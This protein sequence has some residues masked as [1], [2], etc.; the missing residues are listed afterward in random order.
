[1]KHR[2]NNNNSFYNISKILKSLHFK[3]LA[4]IKSSKT[5]QFQIKIY[6]CTERNIFHLLERLNWY[7]YEQKHSDD[8]KGYC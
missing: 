8:A 3:E 7:R 4:M 5:N 1:V 2:N 6:S